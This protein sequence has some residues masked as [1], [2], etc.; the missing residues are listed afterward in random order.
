VSYIQSCLSLYDDNLKIFGGL[1]EPPGI[2][3]ASVPWAFPWYERF[4]V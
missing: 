1:K 2:E 4:F 3:K